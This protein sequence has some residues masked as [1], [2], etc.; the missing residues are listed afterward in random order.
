MILSRCELEFPDKIKEKFFLEAK[1]CLKKLVKEKIYSSEVR[2]LVDEAGKR[3][4]VTVNDEYKM[5][6][7]ITSS[8]RTEYAFKKGILEEIFKNEKALRLVTFLN[9]PSS[10]QLELNLLSH[11]ELL[12]RQLFFLASK[13]LFIF[14]VRKFF[15]KKMG[16]EFENP[17]TTLVAHSVLIDKM[18][19]N[20]IFIDDCSIVGARTILQTHG[21]KTD[22]GYGLSYSFG[23]I[24]FMKGAEVGSDCI[25]LPGSIIGKNCSVYPMTVVKRDV[26]PVF[27]NNKVFPVTYN[28]RE[29]FPYRVN[30]SVSEIE[31]FKL[32]SPLFFKFCKGRLVLSDEDAHK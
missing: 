30:L 18:A 27:L 29:D 5:D 9:I 16:V 25:V 12:R 32:A 1:C 19:P 15:M 2:L 22:K 17:K 13:H 24:Y 6:E 28:Q 8:I 21:V 14:S 31:A 11:F 10:S 4:Y 7:N 20:L 3:L 23:P 26:A